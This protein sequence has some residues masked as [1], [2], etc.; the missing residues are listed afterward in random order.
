MPNVDAANIAYNLLRIAA[1]HGITVGG[2]LLGAAR[3]AHVLTPSATVRRIVNMTALATVDANVA[4]RRAPEPMP[5][6]ETVLKQAHPGSAVTPRRGAS[7]SSPVAGA[8]L[9]KPPWLR[10]P[11]P[12]ERGL[13]RGQAGAARAAPAHR[14]R[15][16]ALPEHRRVLQP[17]HR[18]LHGA[19][20][21]VHA[22]LPVLRRGARPAAAAR[23]ERA[24][25]P[26][27]DGGAAAPVVRGDHE[28][29]SRRPA[30]R[31]RGALRRVHPRRARALAGDAHRGADA[32]LPRPAR[33]GARPARSRPARRD[34]PQPRDRAAPVSRG[35][36][37]RR[38]RAFAAPAGRVQAALPRRP[39]QVG[40]DARPRRNRRRSRRRHARPA[41]ARRRHADHRPVPATEAGQPAGPAL[42]HAFAIRRAAQPAQWPWASRTPRAARWCARA[43]RPTDKPMRPGSDHPPSRPDLQHRS[44]DHHGLRPDPEALLQVAVL[45]GHHRHRDRCA[46]RATST[47]RPAPR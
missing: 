29:R 14:L 28:R 17:R 16:G 27:R 9:A 42:R 41:R 11:L 34:E 35:S 4:A 7:R 22:A 12:D 44:G 2:I 33:S 43:T 25:A 30:R 23:C 37:R 19:R 5:A 6:S 18:H 3:P 36:P 10:V 38:L 13:S 39:H 46:A 21:P 15:R 1:G 40:P 26:G 45:P 31:R 47:R 8:P 24:A 32:R 20:R